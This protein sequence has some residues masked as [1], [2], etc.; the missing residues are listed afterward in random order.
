MYIEHKSLYIEHKNLY[1]EHP[2]CIT[3]TESLYNEHKRHV[4][5][6]RN[7]VLTKAINLVISISY[8]VSSFGANYLLTIL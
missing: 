3:N 7:L 4:Y 2:A 8:A 5:R 6:T 1:N